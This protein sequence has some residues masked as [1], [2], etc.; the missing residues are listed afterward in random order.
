MTRV[1]DFLKAN[2]FNLLVPSGVE[3]GRREAGAGP[4]RVFDR[5]RT[6]SKVM[7]EECPNGHRR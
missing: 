5:L 1:I 2:L 4:S 7:G 3:F 6:V